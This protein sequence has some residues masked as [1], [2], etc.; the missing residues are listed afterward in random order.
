[1][2]KFKLPLF[3][4]AQYFYWN[5]LQFWTLRS[6]T[7]IPQNGWKRKLFS[8]GHWNHK[9]RSKSWFKNE[10]QKRDTWVGGKNDNS[11]N[12]QNRQKYFRGS[13]ISFNNSRAFE[14]MESIVQWYTK[15]L[16]KIKSSMK[17]NHVFPFFF[18]LFFE[19]NIQF[20]NT[21]CDTINHVRLNFM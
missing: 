11:P 19:K 13:R 18:F 21:N 4:F 7:I 6:N 20:R 8:Y 17:I 15:V 1:M 16:L 2:V 12:F 9:D 5:L 10:A 14:K 3:T